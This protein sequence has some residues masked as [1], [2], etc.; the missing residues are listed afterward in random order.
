MLAAN[1]ARDPGAGVPPAGRGRE[2]RDAA[3]VREKDLIGV[4]GIRGD[5]YT[6]T[7][8]TD[9]IVSLEGMIAA[10]EARG[11]S[12]FGICVASVQTETPIPKRP[13]CRGQGT[14]VTS[15]HIGAQA[16]RAVCLLAVLG[17]YGGLSSTPSSASRSLSHSLARS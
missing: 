8:L 9:G 3:T 2:G 17:C 5:L 10:A 12:G 15:V 11:Y 13:A 16:P 1:V 4:V 6:H 7:D 14:L